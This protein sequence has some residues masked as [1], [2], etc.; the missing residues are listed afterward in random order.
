MRLGQES[1]LGSILKSNTPEVP[2]K[3]DG[4]ILFLAV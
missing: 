2:G 4:S 3:E 1:A